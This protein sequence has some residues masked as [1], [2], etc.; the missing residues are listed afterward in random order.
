MLTVNK[1][2]DTSFEKKLKEVHQKHN[3]HISRPNEKK[4]QYNGVFDRFRYPVITAEHTPV[5]WRYDLNPETNPNLQQRLGINSTCN[6]GAIKWKDKYLLAVRVEGFDRKSIFG[7][8]ES[9]NGID[10]FRFWDYPLE[11]PETD[12]PD[13]NT[14]DLRLTRH[15][16]GWIYGV[17]CTERKDP[18]APEHDKSSAIAQAGIARTKDLIN[19][20][21]LPD[22]STPSPQQRNVV[23]HPEFL[24]GKYAFYT[25]PQDGFISTGSG[26]GIG[27]G[28]CDDIENPRIDQEKIIDHRI[29]HTIKEVKNGQGPPPIKT[30]EGWLHLAHG[31]RDTV[32][33]FRYV[34][35]MFMTDLNDPSK[36]IYQPGGYF[37]APDKD[38]YVGDVS[39]VVFSSGWIADDDGTVFIYYASADTRMHVATSHVDLLVDYVKNTPQ[40][41]LRSYACV[42]QRSELIRKNLDY[43]NG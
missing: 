22:L 37:M 13:T 40:D 18:D 3:D 21:R 9:P 42:K 2:H 23:L 35:Y 29:Y 32:A 31:V 25:R 12:D 27:W 6:S 26:S 43:L 39:N 41:A 24:D 36:V 17:F 7:I 4:D 11:I 34:L 28:V 33:G 16:D 5:F 38:E 20:Q 19:W 15:E 10:N 14:Y 8:A 1:N 30:N